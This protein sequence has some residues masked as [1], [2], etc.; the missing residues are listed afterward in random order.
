[1][2][3]GGF[4]DVSSLSQLNLNPLQKLS[5]KLSV[6]SNFAAALEAA[7][8]SDV[9]TSLTPEVLKTLLDDPNSSIPES[10]RSS[11]KTLFSDA[12]LPEKSV[13]ALSKQLA[14]YASG[15]SDVV[16]LSS[17]AT[18]VAQ[19]DFDLQI[20]TSGMFNLVT[21]YGQKHAMNDLIS[22][23]KKLDT[24]SSSFENIQE[25]F[26]EFSKT[27][28]MG[29]SGRPDLE[30]PEDKQQLTFDMQYAMWIKIS[31]SGHLERSKVILAAFEES[32]QMR[33][34]K[35][36]FKGEPL[37]SLVDDLSLDTEI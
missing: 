9:P 7:E 29:L 32:Q 31:A 24:R 6:D 2:K 37:D 12:V 35:L 30:K 4:V 11:L 34:A 26:I 21:E 18:E 5:S 20:V 36:E 14:V 16:N 3:G 28:T 10:I 19:A 8:V 25:N 27:G 13:T 17:N 33:L 15:L 23:W 22:V 1:M